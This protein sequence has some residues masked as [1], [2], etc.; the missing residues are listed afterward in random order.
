M[1]GTH[2]HTHHTSTITI[3]WQALQ[4]KDTDHTA[5]NKH[6]QEDLLRANGKVVTVSKLEYDVSD[7]VSRHLKQ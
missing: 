5:E 4:R 7:Q 3:S 6:Q 1:M 2:T